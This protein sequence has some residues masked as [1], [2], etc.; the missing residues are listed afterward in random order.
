MDMFEAEKFNLHPFHWI[1]PLGIYKPYFI[2]LP[3][4]Y[5]DKFPRLL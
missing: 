3:G 5:I 1:Y 4:H 2:R